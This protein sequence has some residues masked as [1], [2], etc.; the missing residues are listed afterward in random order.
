MLEALPAVTVP[1]S[2]KAGRSLRSF[3]LLL[4]RNLHGDDLAFEMAFLPRLHCL[5]VGID[6]E[7]VL[8]FA[9]NFVFVGD[10]LAGQPHVVVVVNIPKAVVHNRVDDLRIAEAVSLARLRQQIRH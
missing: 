10:V 2:P 8:L 1:F 9:G 5:A 4:R 7:L 6:G 3:A